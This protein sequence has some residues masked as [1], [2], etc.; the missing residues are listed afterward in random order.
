M[1]DLHKFGGQMHGT[2]GDAGIMASYSFNPPPY[3]F[4]VP[5]DS[6]RENTAKL[7]VLQE[8]ITGRQ[9]LP[10]F[11]KQLR[12]YERTQSTQRQH[13]CKKVHLYKQ[14]HTKIQYSLK[15]TSI[16]SAPLHLCVNIQPFILF[17]FILFYFILFYFI[18]FYFISFP[19]FSLAVFA[20]TVTIY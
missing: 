9:N 7:V 14:W 20:W 5:S 15:Y 18:L 2:S 6:N 8:R 1:Y 10:Q 16:I 12:S 13:T 19:V 4:V 11:K 17:Y 3:P